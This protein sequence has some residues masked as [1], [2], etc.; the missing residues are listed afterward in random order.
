MSRATALISKLDGV[1]KKYNLTDR[2][3]YKRTVT[4]S[5]GDTVTG[6][7][8]VTVNTDVVLSPQ[9]AVRQLSQMDMYTGVAAMAQ[10]GDSVCT[11]SPTAVTRTELLN[12]NLLFVFKDASDNEEECFIVGFIPSALNGVDVAFD[13]VVRSKKR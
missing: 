10:I 1:L 13:V 6:K 2:T 5:G 8:V 4:R 11:V 3:V 12:K 9:P 7:G